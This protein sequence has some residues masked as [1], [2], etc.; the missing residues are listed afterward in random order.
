MSSPAVRFRISR[1]VTSDDVLV[2]VVVV[3]GL[4]LGDELGE[5]VH[6]DGVEVGDLEDVT[7]GDVV[8]AVASLLFDRI[9]RKYHKL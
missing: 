3:V 2:V 5:F 9:A 4:P 8:D 6:D 7:V 1:K